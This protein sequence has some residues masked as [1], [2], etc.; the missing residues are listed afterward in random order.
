M[1]QICY[2]KHMFYGKTAAAAALAS[3]GLWMYCGLSR[4]LQVSRYVI[5]SDKIPAAFDG[6][7]IV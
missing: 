3:F 1:R 7:K 4:N 2:T 5:D 6:F